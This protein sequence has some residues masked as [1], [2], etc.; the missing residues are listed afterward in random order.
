[1]CNNFFDEISSTNDDSSESCKVI[2]IELD[3]ASSISVILAGEGLLGLT[4]RYDYQ[5]TSLSNY[6]LNKWYWIYVARSQNSN[7]VNS[8]QNVGI[9]DPQ[10]SG[11][12]VSVSDNWGLS[13]SLAS[14]SSTG[15]MIY[16]NGFQGYAQGFCGKL[17]GIVVVPGTSYSFANAYEYLAQNQAGGSVSDLLLF[18]PFDANSG[19]T[20]LDGSVNEYDGTLGSFPYPDANDPTWETVKN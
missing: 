1:M 9:Y 10:Q 8:V 14:L 2:S 20:V 11:Y 15:F 7:L 18:L 4:S 5:E 3:S 19:Q 6:V 16:V 13:Y 17:R 12:V